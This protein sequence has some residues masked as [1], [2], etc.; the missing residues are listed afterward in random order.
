MVSLS[1]GVSHVNKATIFI[2]GLPFVFTLVEHPLSPSLPTGAPRQTPFIIVMVA[3]FYPGSIHW[4]SDWHQ[5]T[6]Q[7]LHVH[8]NPWY[9]VII[10]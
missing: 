3:M 6:M 1:F 4:R 8:Y 7:E 10:T 9:Y 2:G 5:L